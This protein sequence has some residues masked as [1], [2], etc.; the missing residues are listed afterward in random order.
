MTAPTSWRIHHVELSENLPALAAPA[1][2]RGVYL[3]FWWQGVPIGDEYV[4]AESLP[5][6]AAELAEIASRAVTEGVGAR[7]FG[8][9]F[10]Q[11]APLGTAQD[12][13]APSVDTDALGALDRPLARLTDA[14]EPPADVSVSV[15]VCTRD[16]PQPLAQC[17]A[18]LRALDPPPDEIV[19]VDNASVTDETRA[20]AQAAPGV[21]YVRESRPGLDVARNAGAR[22]STG[23]V[24]AYVDDDVEVHPGWLTGLRRGFRAPEVLAVTGLVLPAELETEAQVAFETHWSFNKGFAPIT[25][26]PAFF[27]AGAGKGVPVWEIGAG[28]NMAFRRTAFDRVGWFDER[29]DVGAAGCSGDSEFWFRILA[30]GGR[31]RYEPSAVVFHTHRRDLDALDQQIAAYMR[32]AVAAHLVQFEKYRRWG[33]LRRP[34]LAVPRYYLHLLR[35]R[36]QKGKGLR[37]RTLA[38]EVRG[39]V[40]GLLFYLRNRRPPPGATAP[41][42]AT[43]PG[44]DAA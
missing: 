19:V 15:V 30:E 25:Y 37:T 17:L 44:T 22:A 8:A 4:R 1:D 16:R 32:G 33:D 20:V 9:R 23:D 12:E 43:S 11:K 21:R 10:R 35:L 13:G 5:I 34:F 40:S 2:G 28:A 41:L 14:L 3:V 26:G 29:L 36:L 18:A 27:E 42:V 6:P 39:H 7:L 24:V 31:C 38:P